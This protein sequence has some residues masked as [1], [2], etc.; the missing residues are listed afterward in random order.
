MRVQEIAEKLQA[1]ILAQGEL[2]RSEIER[3]WAGDRI[4]D[5]LNQAS[6]STLVI[7]H[8]LSTHLVRVAELVDLAAVCLVGGQA[9]DEEFLSQA[10]GVGLWVITSPVDL[11][12]T[13]GRLYPLFFARERPRS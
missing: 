3:A 10:R 13:C 7:T 9:P 12:E 4:S 1:R 6:G 5:L 11:F 2:A 8:A